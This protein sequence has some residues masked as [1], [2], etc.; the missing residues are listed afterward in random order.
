MAAFAMLVPVSTVD[1]HSSSAKS[2]RALSRACFDTAIEPP[3]A[4]AKP[5]WKGTS[6]LLSVKLSSLTINC[7]L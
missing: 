1:S 2:T 3:L 5:A 4:V 7:T 6:M